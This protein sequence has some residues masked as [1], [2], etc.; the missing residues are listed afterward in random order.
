MSLIP[1]ED[2][3]RRL[4]DGSRPFERVETLPL[5]EAAGRVLSRPLAARLTQPPFDNSAMDGYAVQS[6]DVAELGRCP[7]DRLLE[8]GF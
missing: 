7:S 6:G 1:V 8:R 3:L 2:A 5:S 4:I